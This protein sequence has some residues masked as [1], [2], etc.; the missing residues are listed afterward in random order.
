MKTL[1]FLSLLFAL[2]AFA[3]TD[4]QTIV[5]SEIRDLAQ[6]QRVELTAAKS[7]VRSLTASLTKARQEA[8]A[9]KAWGAGE[10]AEK[11]KALESASYWQSKHAKSLREIWFWRGLAATIVG[12]VLAVVG[13]R[14]ARRLA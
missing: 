11:I 10:Q 2:P 5:V 3:L 7:D 1:L 4:E 14:V 13:F 9:L 6:A 12:A 8:S